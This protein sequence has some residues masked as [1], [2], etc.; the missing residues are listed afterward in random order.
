M[1]RI[2]RP[3]RMG[4]EREAAEVVVVGSSERTKNAGTILALI[5]APTTHGFTDS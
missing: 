3:S 2:R 1:S 5:L 4:F